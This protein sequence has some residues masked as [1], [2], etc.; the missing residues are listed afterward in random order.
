MR[1][2][3]VRFPLSSL[4]LRGAT[5][6][7]T[8]MICTTLGGCAHKMPDVAPV[9]DVC[10]EQKAE[11]ES[12][13][14]VRTDIDQRLK[15]FSNVP[16][17]ATLADQMFEQLIKAKSP[18]LVSWMQTR[19]LND[20]S[21]DEIIYAWRE[22]FAKIFVIGQYPT[23]SPSLNARIEALVKNLREVHLGADVE[24][25]VQTIFL[26]AQKLSL[27]KVQNFTLAEDARAQIEKKISSI[28]LYWAQDLRGSKF[29]KQ[30]LEFVDWGVAYDP[31]ANE[32]NIGIQVLAYPSDENLLAVFAHEIGHAIDSCR[33][34]AFFSGPWP[35]S[36]V[37][38]CLRS[39]ES[40][41]AKHR[42][43]T[44]LDLFVARKKLTT[45][46]ADSL[47]ANPTCNRTIYPPP[48]VQA[49]QLPETFADWFSAEVMGEAGIDVRHLR[50]DLCQNRNLNAGSAYVSNQFRLNKIYLSQPK[51]RGQLEG[52]PATNKESVRSKGYCA[53]R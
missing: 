37:G 50:A 39:S 38:E 30:P 33:W 26:K 29:E 5:L 24:K 49:D 8:I 47:R 15:K 7:S 19:G 40:V 45:E 17:V 2:F 51:L 32:I 20:K 18:V 14:A 52:A 21:E 6:I 23:K 43:D 10:K 34:G 36:L 41:G 27:A 4:L 22:Y 1:R 48:D 28:K 12:F 46:M 53:F 44:K 3:G 35:F 13:A 31:A 25:R 9:V 42:D 11:A 16:E